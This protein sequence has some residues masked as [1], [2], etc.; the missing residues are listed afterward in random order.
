MVGHVEEPFE[1]AGLFGRELA[2]QEPARAALGT[3]AAP[4]SYDVGFVF[5]AVVV[6]VALSCR[7]SW[8]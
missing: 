5:I 7:A 4:F 3:R 8:S 1:S 6:A 2:D